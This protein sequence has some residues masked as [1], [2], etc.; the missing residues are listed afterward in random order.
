MSELQTS[1]SSGLNRFWAARN[2][3]SPN[4]RFVEVDVDTTAYDQGTYPRRRRLELAEPSSRTTSAG[5]LIDKSTLEKLL[6]A[7]PAFSND[8]PAQHPFS[9]ATNNKLVRT[10]TPFWQLKLNGHRDVRPHQRWP[11]EMR[12]E[13]KRPVTKD[14]SKRYARV[15]F[16]SPAPTMPFA[17]ARKKVFAILEGRKLRP[18]R[19]CSLRR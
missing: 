4:L 18:A 2:L 13:E 15:L 19:R 16:T 7:P 5:I 9:M 10:P 17:L 14:P 3:N 11:E 8:T 1:R 6:Q 12:L